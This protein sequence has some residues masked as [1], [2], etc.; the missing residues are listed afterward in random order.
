MSV[1][2]LYGTRRKIY[3]Y[4]LR[5]KNAVSIRKIQRDLNLSS[6][7]LVQYHLKKLEED[8]LIKE[9]EK[10]YV[11]SKVILSDYVKFA[12][13]L[14]PI[15]A[16]LASFFL[17]SLI[18]LVVFLRSHIIASQVFSDIIIS[19]SAS[20]FVYDVIKKYREIKL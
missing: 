19:I 15:S 6:P 10:G 16:F 7:S 4:I 5:Q 14:I 1:E 12:N 8:G 3:Y 18:I 13:F 9:T 11:V 2:S 17:T 20:I